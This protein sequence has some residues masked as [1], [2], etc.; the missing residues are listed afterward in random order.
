[1]LR[2]IFNSSGASYFCI[3]LSDSCH[4]CFYKK[5]VLYCKKRKQIE[6]RNYFLMTPQSL[7]DIYYLP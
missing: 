3:V 6:N 1:M 4:F 7:V 5:V 2:I